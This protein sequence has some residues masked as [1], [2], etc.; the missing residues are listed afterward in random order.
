MFMGGFGPFSGTTDNYAIALV[1]PEERFPRDRDVTLH[2]P[3]SRW[4]AIDAITGMDPIDPSKQ[5]VSRSTNT[6]Q[7]RVPA[8]GYRLIHFVA[9]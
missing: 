2:I 9:Q 6:L 5:P 3:L 1:D 4:T 8:G 7:V